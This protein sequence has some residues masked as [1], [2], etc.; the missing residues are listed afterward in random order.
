MSPVSVFL[1]ADLFRSIAEGGDGSVSEH[2][3]RNQRVHGANDHD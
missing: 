2:E 1:R 3:E